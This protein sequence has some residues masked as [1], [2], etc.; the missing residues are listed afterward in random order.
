MS[1]GFG[2]EVTQN[3]ISNYGHLVEFTTSP[4][5]ITIRHTD[6]H[7]NNTYYF[8]T[9]VYGGGSNGEISYCYI[10]DIY[11]LPF[12]MFGSWQGLLLQYNYIARSQ[13]TPAEHTGKQFCTFI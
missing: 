2:F 6:I 10:H 5:N 12:H 3:F 4:D 7:P 13:S 11:G 8:A 9:G 1:T